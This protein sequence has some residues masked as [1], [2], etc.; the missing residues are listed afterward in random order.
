M[1]DLPGVIYDIPMATTSMVTWS[2]V[3]HL[4]IGL[5]LP[6][7]AASQCHMI[8]FIFFLKMHIY[9]QFSSKHDLNESIGSLNDCHK[10]GHKVGSIMWVT[11]F[12]SITTW[13]IIVHYIMIVSQGWHISKYYEETEPL[14]SVFFPLVFLLILV[15]S[16]RHLYNIFGGKART[17]V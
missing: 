5:H 9:F 2:H 16:V 1:M 6:S 11:C 12:M 15:L 4:A 8:A 14:W 10:N 3:K 7:F 13:S 17:Y